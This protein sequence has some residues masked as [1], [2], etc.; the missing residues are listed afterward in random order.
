MSD[1]FKDIYNDAFYTQ[2][3]SIVSNVIPS[4]S[5]EKFKVLIFSES[6]LSM[7]L[8]ERMAHTSNVLHHFL[9]PCF[10]TAAKQVVS[11]IEALEACSIKEKSIEY[12]FFPLYIEQFGIED[13]VCSI[14]AFERIT[15]FTSCE[16]AVR[17]FLKRYPQVM[18]DQMIDW[19]KHPHASVRRLASEGSRPRL[20]WAMALPAFK[21]DPKPLI[22]ILDALK[23]D[24]DEV[25]RRSVANNL[26]DIAKDNPSFVVSYA[27]DHLGETIATD[28][29]IKHACRTLL[30][31]GNIEILALYGLLSDKLKV[32]NLR[33][34][35]DSVEVGSG[36]TFSFDLA[37]EDETSRTVRIEYAIHY[38]KKN[39]SLSP[40]VFKISERKINGLQPLSFTRKQSFKIITTR[41]F[42]VG[43]HRI[44]IIV[45]G[46][47]FVNHDFELLPSSI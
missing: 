4:C 7:E 41:T 37:N 28:K 35:S 17:P 12:M 43:G 8:K 36:L 27:T 46:K 10:S 3:S 13:L 23:N 22:P 42:H 31:Q 47:T 34:E 38:L 20:P 32:D 29:L 40:K 2:F 21:S 5:V 30:K 25:V 26:N 15:Q 39:G 14:S 18:L 44:S 6:F 1:L 16:F 11:I 24:E 33:L 45:N 9:D 19:T